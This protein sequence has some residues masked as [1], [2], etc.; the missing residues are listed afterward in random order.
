MGW[1]CCC[2]LFSLLHSAIRCVRGSRSSAGSFC[3]PVLTNAVGLV[4]AETGLTFLVLYCLCKFCSVKKYVQKAP[5]YHYKKYGQFYYEEK[6]PLA[7]SQDE[8]NTKEDTGKSMKDAVYV[9]RYA[10]RHF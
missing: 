2:L 8:W 9:L 5:Q 1:L 10:K 6:T 7:V 4:Q 3:R